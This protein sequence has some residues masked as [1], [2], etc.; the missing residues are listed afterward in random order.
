MENINR[1]HLMVWVATILLA[2]IVTE[3]LI[4]IQ[5]NTQNQTLAMAK[6]GYTWVVL[7][8]GTGTGEYRKINCAPVPQN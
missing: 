2:G 1:N 4:R 3:F 7:P 6:A 5:I 8:G